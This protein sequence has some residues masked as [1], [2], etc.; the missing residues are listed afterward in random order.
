MWELRS[1]SKTVEP[2]QSLSMNILTHILTTPSQ[3]NH[4]KLAEAN[5]ARL[6]LRSFILNVARLCEAYFACSKSPGN[7]FAGLAL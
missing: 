1:E 2:T 4:S 6:T 7:Y 5:F 3:L